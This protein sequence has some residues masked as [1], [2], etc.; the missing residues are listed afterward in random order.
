MLNSTQTTPT[1]YTL[2]FC[3]KNPAILY[4][5]VHTHGLLSSY[6]RTSAALIY[7]YTPDILHCILSYMI[8][9]HFVFFSLVLPVIMVALLYFTASMV[10]ALSTLDEL[11]HECTRKL[12]M[13]YNNKFP[14]VLEKQ[15]HK[16]CPCYNLNTRQL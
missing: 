9:L 11:N 8:L 12:V 4:L 1:R 14:A 6:R 3:K 5:H 2:N 15:K 16:I 13:V 7:M 10:W